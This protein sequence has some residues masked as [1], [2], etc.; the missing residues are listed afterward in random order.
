M[1][2]G[3]GV[4]TPV[5]EGGI[6]AVIKRGGGRPYIVE[7]TPMSDRHADPFETRARRIA[8]RPRF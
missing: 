1:A 5:R 3:A 6:V 4:R 8:V 2:V 7:I